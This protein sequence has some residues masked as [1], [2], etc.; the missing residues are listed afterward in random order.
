MLCLIRLIDLAPRPVAVVAELQQPMTI[1][2][3]ILGQLR[4]S[5]NSDTEVQSLCNDWDSHAVV[6]QPALFDAKGADVVDVL[7]TVALEEPHRILQKP[8]KRL[9]P[10]L[11]ELQLS[12]VQYVLRRRTPTSS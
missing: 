4:R 12:V 3:S 7:A 11:S 10:V 5:L 8:L 9:P 2:S 1:V 6:V